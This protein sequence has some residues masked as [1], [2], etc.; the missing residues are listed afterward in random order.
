M[1]VSGKNILVIDDEKGIQELFRF[2]LETEGYHVTVAND[3]RDGVEIVKKEDFSLIFLDVHMPRMKGPEALRI[4]KQM[5]PD[6]PIVI[7]SSS[8]D[9]NHAFER[10]AKE[11]GAFECIYKPSTI[12]EIL[13]VIERVLGKSK[14]VKQKG[15]F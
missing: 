9:A 11:L 1:N 8:S 6:I 2:L 10:R 4:I 5:K 14:E 7:F 13:E 12:E 15:N 3:G